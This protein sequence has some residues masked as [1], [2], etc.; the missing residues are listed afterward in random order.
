MAVVNTDDIGFYTYDSLAYFI[1][2]DVECAEITSK[3]ALVLMNRVNVKTII[4]TR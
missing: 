1:F 4:R 2:I 3:F